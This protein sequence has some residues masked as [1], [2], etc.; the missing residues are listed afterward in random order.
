MANGEWR[1][2]NKGYPAPVVSYSFKKDE[3]DIN[4]YS[5]ATIRSIEFCSGPQ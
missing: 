2:K 3:C 4:K 1:I 5:R